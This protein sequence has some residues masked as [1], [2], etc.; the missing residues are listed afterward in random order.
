[1]KSCPKKIE[2]SLSLQCYTER[3]FC[4]SFSPGIATGRP[5]LPFSNQSNDGS[6]GKSKSGWRQAVIFQVEG[7]GGTR[8]RRLCTPISGA[9][10]PHSWEKSATW[11]WMETMARQSSRTRVMFHDPQRMQETTDSTF[12]Y[13]FPLFL[14]PYDKV[15]FI[16]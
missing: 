7:K 1:M 14:H 12:I 16:N 6:C 8:A 9:C 10:G 11:W 15:Q 4:V 13:C 2:T 3:T 5:Y